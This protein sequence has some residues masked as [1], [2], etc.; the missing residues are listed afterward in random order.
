MTH[1]HKYEILESLPVYGPMYIPITENDNKVFYS[2]G[3]PVRFFKSDGTDW[4]ANF[5]PGFTSLR[6]IFELENSPNILVIAYGICYLINPDFPKPIAIF[7][8]DYDFVFKTNDGRLVLQD[9]IGLTIV[10]TNGEYWDSERI[11]I[12]GLKDLSLENNCVT[13]L[14]SNPMNQMDEWI[15]FTYNIDTKE[16]IGGSFY[17]FEIIKK[18]WWKVW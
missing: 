1:S 7:G 14:A 13:G 16:L 5:N 4:V 8:Y 12:D 9:N 3:F 18:P 6:E 17:V 2:E 15:P 11:S 10:E